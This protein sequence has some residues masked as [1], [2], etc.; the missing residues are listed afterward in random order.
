MGKDEAG[1]KKWK[2]NKSYMN[3]YITDAASSIR[4][5]DAEIDEL[6]GDNNPAV[7]AAKYS[8]HLNNGHSIAVQ[9][10]TCEIDKGSG[11][12]TFRTNGRIQYAFS[13]HYFMYCERV[14]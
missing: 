13:P 2:K 4:Y 7:E 11:T 3:Q 8:V 6:A 9:A 5:H 14:H 12:L 1:K 10:E